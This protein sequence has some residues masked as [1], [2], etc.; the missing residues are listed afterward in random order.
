MTTS[1]SD[2]RDEGYRVFSWGNG[3]RKGLFTFE[4]NGQVDS[5][6]FETS[7]AAWKAAYDHK[8][9]ANPIKETS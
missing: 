9:K 4:H 8:L 5:S 3:A 6:C 1:L 2:A 7:T